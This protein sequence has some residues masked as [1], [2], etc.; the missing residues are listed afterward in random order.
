[1]TSLFNF[2]LGKNTDEEE[3]IGL[4]NEDKLYC[5]MCNSM[6][7]DCGKAVKIRKDIN[8][9]KNN[10]REYDLLETYWKVDSILNFENIEIHSRNPSL[11]YL[12]CLFCEGL[13]L[14]IQYIHDPNNIL[15]ACDRVK[16]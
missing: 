4:P 16:Y 11:K 9:V 6:V 8:M 14:G 13:I 12:T 10:R 3:K 5:T 1:M 2:S 7:L 15:I